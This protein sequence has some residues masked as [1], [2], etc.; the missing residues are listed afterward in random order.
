MSAQS[1]PKNIYLFKIFAVTWVGLSALSSYILIKHLFW[2]TTSL[3]CQPEQQE[4]ICRISGEPGPGETRKLSIP[5]AQLAGVKV[6]SQKKSHKQRS[7]RQ[8][9]LIDINQ[10]EIPLTAHWGGEATHQ[11][12]KEI[13]RMTAFIQDPQAQTLSIVTHREIPPPTIPII[14][15]IAFVDLALLKQVWQRFK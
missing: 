2:E 10:Q 7:T 3:Q 4:V 12:L 5:K 13:D 1:A 8:V 14:G 11:L 6:L 9:V 15:F